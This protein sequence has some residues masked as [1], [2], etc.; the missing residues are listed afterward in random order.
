MIEILGLNEGR[1]FEAAKHLKRKLLDLWPDLNRSR[2]DIVKIFVG[3]KL[4]GHQ[5]EDLD[6]ILIGHFSQERDFDVEMKF[7][8][9]DGEPY[10][11]KNAAVKNIA[12]VLEVKSHDPSGVKFH[13][14]VAMVKYPQ[15]WVNV[16]EKNRNQVFELKKYLQRNGLGSIYVKDLIFFTGL[17]ESNFPKRPH[18][19][20]GIDASFERILNILGQISL[21]HHTK[22]YVTIN[23]GSDDIFESIIEGHT[24]LF[25]ILEPTPLDRKR[26]DR[27]IKSTISS[28]WLDDLGAKQ[29]RIKG[30]GG[31]GKTV[32][33][34]QMAYKAFDTKQLRSLVLTYNKALVADMRRTMALLGVPRNI[35][36]GGISIDTVHSFIGKIMSEFGILKYEDNFLES[37][38]HHKE[39]LLEFIRSGAIT[40][41]DINKLRENHADLFHWDL[42][43]IDEG[44]DWPSNEID[45]IRA[46][47]PPQTVVV[48]DGVDQ[49]VRSTIADWERGLGNTMHRTRRLRR[50]LRMKSN[51]A[52]FVS[53]CADEFGLIDWD[54]EPNNEANGGRV[55][56]VKGDMSNN[57]SL[58]KKVCNEASKMG[59]YPVDMLACV[60]PS[61]VKHTDDGV[62]STPGKAIVESGAKVWDA[63]STDIREYYPTD[64]DALRIVQY[65]SCRGLEG[66][67]VI[68]YALDEFFE[69]KRL[70][71]LNSP[72]ELE[73]LFDSQ[74]ELAKNY[75]V[76]WMMIPLTRAMDTLVINIKDSE[77]ELGKAIEKVANNC[78]DFVEWF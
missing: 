78:K 15:G 28:E 36:Q 5:I 45:I 26:M 7:H 61:L 18:N 39:N 51:L 17:R 42:V 4:Y 60:P 76:Q 21:P 2:K 54:L 37:Y 31:V 72:K 6:L 30:R 50:C 63:T 1:E 8:Q 16:T 73:G 33:L 23:H 77:S 10:V 9:K 64:R 56:I 12:L 43:F 71:W 29:V 19:C 27:I 44:Q 52:C 49:Y 70:Q 3:L 57:T 75:A 34:L 24:E 41:A 47:Y 22:K 20:F 59:N 14:K 62:Y 67:T 69:V 53:G 46:I 66:W 40:E 11:P 48:A 58:Y 55:L 32:I 35:E 25:K 65:E 13:D 38:D 68:N 74:E